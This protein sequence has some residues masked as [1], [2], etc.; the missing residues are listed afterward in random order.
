MLVGLLVHFGEGR[1][2][3]A[4]VV[5]RC[6][7]MLVAFVFPDIWHIRTSQPATQFNAEIDGSYCTEGSF[8]DRFDYA[9]N[10]W[11][12]RY[13][14]YAVCIALLVCASFEKMFN[15]CPHV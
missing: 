8:A 2:G 15:V 12:F 13:G 4:A 11:M 6:I 1:A 5:Y 10:S 3:S 14:C 7:G 9:R